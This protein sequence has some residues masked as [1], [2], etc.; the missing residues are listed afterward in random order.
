MGKFQISWTFVYSIRQLKYTSLAKNSVYNV[1]G[2]MV[3]GISSLSLATKCAHT[4]Q[5]ACG[6]VAKLPG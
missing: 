5:V 4:T 6:V 2:V 1:K 3:I